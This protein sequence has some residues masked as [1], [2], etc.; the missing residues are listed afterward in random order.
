[1]VPGSPP[2]DQAL[3]R[4]NEARLEGVRGRGGGP[5]PIFLAL[6]NHDVASNGRCT[7][8]GLDEAAAARRRAC[9]EVEHRSPAWTMPGRH[10]VIDRGPV[11]LVVVDTN[12]V[13][14]DYGG[15]TLDEEVAF[16]RRATAACGPNRPCFLFGH[17]PPAAVHGYPVR[18][19]AGPSPFQARM[20]RLLD[21]AGGRVRAFFAGHVHTLEH[22]SLDGLEVFISGSTAMGGFLPFK[23]RVPAR[24]RLHFA[25]TAWGYAT[26]DADARGYRVAFFDF[27][28]DPLYCCAADGSAPCRA[29]DCG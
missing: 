14:G 20:Q 22:L 15:F 16:V 12:V 18:A 19:T 7:A 24:A 4:E 26:L 2:P 21:A 28:G 3:F 9:L 5:L 27:T 25:T 23:A 17:H 11:R 1:V 13:V 6:G 29:V 10:Y 8:P